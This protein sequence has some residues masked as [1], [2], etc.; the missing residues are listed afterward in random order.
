MWRF[1]ERFRSLEVRDHGSSTSITAFQYTASGGGKVHVPR[2]IWP[3]RELR[4]GESAAH[5][6]IKEAYQKCANCANRQQRVMASISYHILTCKIDH[7]YKDKGGGRFEITDKAVGDI[8]V[9]AAA[10]DTPKLLNEVSCNQTA[11]K[12]VDEHGRTLLYL[13]A[14]SGFYDTTEALLKEGA[15]VNNRQVDGSTPLHG[16]A[17]YS[18]RLIVELLLRYGADPTIK[19]KWGNTALKETSGEISTIISTYKDDRISQ[20]LADLIKRGLVN[21]TRIIEHEGKMIAREAYR[22]TDLLDPSTKRRWD[23]I[24]ANWNLAWHGT[25]S[26]YL[27]SILSNGLMPSGTR[28]RD[29]TLIEPPSNHYKLGEIHFGIRNWARAVF[30]S[31][32]IL[33]ASHA[34][35]SERMVSNSKPWCV[36]IKAYVKPQSYTEHD[37]TVYKYEPIDGEPDQPEYRIDVTENDKILRVESTRNIVVFSLMFIS[38]DILEKS[39]ITYSELISLFV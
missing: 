4:V 33:Y 25:K 12:A 16:A 30:L 29:G 17:Y 7:G 31:P 28:L 8:F 6:E 36:M 3:H 2:H 14:R 23:Q 10:G 27:K 32:S 22:S 1:T 13:T 9:M 39:D 21:K 38:L 19:N 34:C 15:P 20:M 11:L 18:Q 35:Y 5:S 24:L 26:K 37:P